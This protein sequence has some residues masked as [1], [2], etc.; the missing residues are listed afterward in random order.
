MQHVKHFLIVS[1]HL[2][3]RYARCI[4][5]EYRL[6][7]NYQKTYGY[8]IQAGLNSNPLIDWQVCRKSN[9][10]PKY[11]GVLRIQS[12]YNACPLTRKFQLSGGID[13]EQIP[14]L[15]L[16]FVKPGYVW[17]TLSPNLCDNLFQR[18]WEVLRLRKK[19]PLTYT[20]VSL[21]R[22]NT[23]WHTLIEADS[24]VT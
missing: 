8:R 12:I 1:N 16:T 9:K 17:S 3:F 5:D 7:Y 2:H 22:E 21:W 14:A 18:E 19:N 15:Q 4:A 11:L 6:S 23:S 20:L 10:L 24:Q 13:Q